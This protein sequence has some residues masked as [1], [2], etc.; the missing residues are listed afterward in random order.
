MPVSDGSRMITVKVKD[1]GVLRNRL[2]GTCIIP[3]VEVA[4]HGEAGLTKWC[5]LHGSDGL[6]DNHASD[7]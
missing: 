3:M 6:V 1:H 4:A 5:S 7:P 2:I